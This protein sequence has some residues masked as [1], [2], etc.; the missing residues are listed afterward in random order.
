MDYILSES[1]ASV[2]K[3]SRGISHF[4]LKIIA[5]VFMLADLVASYIFETHVFDVSTLVADGASDGYTTAQLIDLFLRL[6]GGI[7]FPIFCFLI[8]EG[9]LHT[10][11]IKKYIL[12]LAITA[13]I[14]EFI[15]DMANGSAIFDFSS[16]NP[17]FTLFT[18]LITIMIIDRFK[19][20]T[21]ITALS[22]C[23]GIV[24]CSFI[25]SQFGTF[26]YGVILIVLMYYTRERKLFFNIF[27]ILLT[28]IASL[29][30]GYIFAAL[31]FTIIPLYNGKRGGPKA[32]VP[33]YFIYPAV[34]LI[35][36]LVGVLF[37]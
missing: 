24:L 21:I 4:I 29:F 3:K 31:A 14:T 17:L 32:V 1:S 30:N 9:L 27:G 12:R 35:L 37:F 25:N 33:F 22:T 23:A 34:L 2:E 5:Y 13:V 10:S 6:A 36:H 7:A 26:G 16:Q 15:W 18:G 8:V 20:H 19:G 11:D 28:V